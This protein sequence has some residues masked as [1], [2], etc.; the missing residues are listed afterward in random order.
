MAELQPNQV[1]AVS[2]E[3][4]QWNTVVGQ[5]MEGPYK[6]MA[7]LIGAIIAQHGKVQQEMNAVQVPE[8]PSPGGQMG[9]RLVVAEGPPPGYVDGQATERSAAHDNSEA[10]ESPAAE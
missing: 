6:V 3:V 10:T 8:A 4:Q 7:P 5:L 9:P 1:I 2:L